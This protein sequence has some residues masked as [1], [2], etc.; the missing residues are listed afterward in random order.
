MTA[1]AGEDLARRLDELAGFVVELAAG[2]LDARLEPSHQSDEIDAIVVGLNMLAEELQ[3]LTHDLEGRV[4]ERTRELADAHAALERLAHSDPL[5]GL[6]NRTLLH[7]R[8]REVERASAVPAVLVLDLDGFKAVNDSFGHEVG[9]ALLVAVAERLRAVVRETDTVA[10]LGGDEFAILVHDATPEQAL[11]IA[12]RIRTVLAAPVVVQGRTC[13]VSAS[14]GVRL[15]TRPG[16]A[17]DDFLR[18]ADTAMYHAKARSRGGVS[19]FAPA[20]RREAQART[21]LADELRSA[22]FTGQLVVLYQPI[23]DLETDHVVAVEALTRWRH[24]ERG[25][26]TPDTFLS[27]AEDTGLITALDL[28]V[29]ET[30]AAQVARWRADVLGDAPFTVHVNVSPVELRAPRFVEDVVDCTRRHGLAPQDVTVEITEHRLLGDDALTREALEGLRAAGVGVAIDDFG[31]GSSSLGYARRAFVDEVKI[32]RSLV[33]DLDVDEQQM[34]ITTAILVMAHAF[35]LVPIAEGVQTAGEA[36]A[37]RRIGCRFGQ[38]YY[39]S[40]PVT[41]TDLELRLRRQRA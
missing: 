2:R 29:L 32:D 39:W 35:D 9:D 17:T 30:A 31:T 37:L 26:L 38:G 7:E 8:L 33:S 21:R 20:M 11:D 12:E 4:V 40:P 27:V 5:T 6:A 23:V 25:F 16:G 14:V 19:V 10:R 36:D 41:A 15:G 13:W 1:H 34:R 28:W 22:L 3:G 24:P 18:D